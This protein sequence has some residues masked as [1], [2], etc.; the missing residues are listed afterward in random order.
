LELYR[1]SDIWLRQETASIALTVQHLSKNPSNPAG[2][3]LYI[4]QQR[5]GFLRTFQ[6]T[7]KGKAS[8]QSIHDYFYAFIIIL[9]DGQL[10]MYFQRCEDKVEIDSITFKCRLATWLNIAITGVVLMAR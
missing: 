9:K 4:A 1:G 6:F 10:E 2:Y 3:T 8:Y 5:F 7:E